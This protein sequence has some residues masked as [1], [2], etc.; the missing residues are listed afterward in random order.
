M[1]DAATATGDAATA[2]G[3]DEFLASKEDL[4]E[5][6]GDFAARF[7]EEPRL[8]K[9]TLDWNRTI[10]VA[11]DDAEDAEFT[12]CLTD[13]ELS[14]AEGRPA[15]KAELVV[16]AD[17]QTLVDLFLGE[18][19]PTEPY[20]SGKLRIEASEADT[21]RLDVITLMIWND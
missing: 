7:A 6:L 4:A 21:M 15:G 2:T 10:L 16:R 8:K 12:L 19:A 5:A 11:P 14:V 17:T 9:M 3:E 18:I 20:M 1:G 13:G